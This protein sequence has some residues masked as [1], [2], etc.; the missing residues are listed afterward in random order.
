M[1]PPQRHQDVAG[2][3]DGVAFHPAAFGVGPGAVAFLQVEELLGDVGAPVDEFAVLGLDVVDLGDAEGLAEGVV[4]VVEALGTET[5]VFVGAVV[6]VD[7]VDDGFDAGVFGIKAGVDETEE[8]GVADA[9]VAAE[10]N[11][12]VGVFDF[13]TAGFGGVVDEATGVFGVFA[14]PARLVALGTVLAALDE[15]DG[16][17]EVELRLVFG[18]VAFISKEGLGVVEGFESEGGV[19]EVGVGG[20]FLTVADAAVGGGV[21]LA[22]FVEIELAGYEVAA[23]LEHDL[24]VFGLVVQEQPSQGDGGVVSGAGLDGDGAVGL[25]VADE[26]AGGFFDLGWDGIARLAVGVEHERGHGQTGDGDRFG[27]APLAGFRVLLGAEEIQ[28]AFDAEAQ[29]LPEGLVAWG[30]AGGLTEGGSGYDE[31]KG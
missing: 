22:F 14:D 21:L 10:G 20:F 27:L 11:G 6:G 4:V 17:T 5:G 13:G 23:G 3:Q 26:V 31:E 25:G 28:T 15:V 8:A 24:L 30:L 16:G 2:G 12:A 9:A 19:G 29:L 7:P 18:G 1:N